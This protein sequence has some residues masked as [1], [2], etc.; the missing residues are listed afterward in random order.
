MVPFA[1]YELPVNYHGG[2]IAEHLLTR[3]HAGL[4]DVSHMGQAF[5]PGADA[6]RKLETLL[7]G[8]LSDPAPREIR[9]SQFTND[10]G[11]V[12]DD[13]MVTQARRRRRKSVPRGQRRLQARRLRAHAKTTC[14]TSRLKCWK[15]APFSPCKARSREVAGAPRPRRSA[16]VFMSL[17][18]FVVARRDVCYVS[19]PAIRARTGLK[20]RSPPI[21]ADDLAE[22]LLAEEEVKAVGLGARNSL[23][24]EAGLCLYGH[25]IDETTSPIEAGPELVDFQTPSRTRAAFRARRAC[26]AN[27]CAGLSARDGLGWRSTARRRRAKARKSPTR[28]ALSSGA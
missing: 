27:F 2:I 23:R 26:S 7:P 19:A 6:A 13:L 15:T 16:L 4:F 25:D 3:E 10:D 21:L 5:L 18:E 12:L 1:G 22:A 9:Y 24:L 11:G 17:Q 20:S 14:P 28:T 8:D